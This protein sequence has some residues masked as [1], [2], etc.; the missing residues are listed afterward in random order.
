MREI[1]YVLIAGNPN[2][3]ASAKPHSVQDF[4]KLSIDKEKKEVE[5]PSPERI[6]QIQDE[7]RELLNKTK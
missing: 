3:K 2:I 6:K 1:C 5:K 7:A 4:M